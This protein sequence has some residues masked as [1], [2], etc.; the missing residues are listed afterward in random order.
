MEKYLKFNFEG[1]DQKIGIYQIYDSLKNRSYIGQATTS[2]ADRWDRHR[3]ALFNP[4]K[5]TQ[6]NTWLKNSF[7]KSILDNDEKG[8]LPEGF[9]VFS[10]IELI[11][12]NLPEQQKLN[13]LNERER[14]WIAEFKRLKNPIYNFKDGGQDWSK[15][16]IEKMAKAN[17][18]RAPW[19]K[20][21]IKP[22]SEQTLRRMSKFSKTK[23]G[24]SNPFFGKTH[25]EESKQKISDS[26]TGNSPAWNKGIPFSDESRQKM[27]EAKKG[28]PG[29][30]HTEESKKLLSE[31]HK[32]ANNPMF[33]KYKKYSVNIISPNG[34]VYTE[35]TSLPE[36]CKEH[37]LNCQGF[38]QFLIKKNKPQYKG[39]IQH[40]KES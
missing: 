18:G 11:D 7:R 5:T 29:N 25:T 15:E 10:I 39:W 26:K 3:L 33:G 13:Q 22:Y 31:S 32:G 12:S 17:I 35:I 38:A 24:E 8:E 37:N 9:I 14:F 36:F 23:T 16:D 28:K 1:N 6:T 21:L 20:G 27:S 19:N 2:F 34:V 40:N 30:P 4:N